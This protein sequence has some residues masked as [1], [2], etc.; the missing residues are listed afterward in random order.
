MLTAVAACVL[1]LSACGQGQPQGQGSPAGT[2]TSD[3]STSSTTPASPTPSSPAAVPSESIAAA[4]TPRCKAD[5]L[6]A[7][8]DSD[9]GGGAAG[10]VYMKLVLTN[11]GGATC[12][13]KG[14]PGVSLTHAPDGEPIGLAASRD[15]VTSVVDVVLAPGQSGTAVLRYVQPGNIPEC[16]QAPAMG[17]RIYPPEETAS[18]FIAQETRACT[19]ADISLL[20]VSPFQT[21]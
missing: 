9:K 1:L 21:A 15:N 2:A 14:F 12:L 18:L 16:S 5:S 6:E 13:L 7:R 4:G 8:M 11:T 17:F 3:S 10:S 20:A 19:N